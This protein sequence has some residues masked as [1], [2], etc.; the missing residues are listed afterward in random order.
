MTTPILRNWLYA[1]PAI[2]LVVVSMCAQTRVEL[3]KTARTIPKDCVLVVPASIEPQIDLAGLVKEALCKGAGEMVADFTFTMEVTTTL[4]DKKGKSKI[5]TSTYEVFVPTLKAGTSARGILVEI[6]KDGKPVPA[7]KLEKERRQA[8]EKLEKEETRLDR[9]APPANPSPG[10]NQGMA[11]IGMYSRSA[12]TRSGR[13]D[14]AF[15]VSSFLKTC[16]LTFLRRETIEGRPSLIFKFAPRAGVSFN[17]GEGYIGQMDGELAIDIE[18]HIVTKL[19]AWPIGADRVAPPAV[20]QDMVRL[21]E[22]TWLPRV[23][24]VNAAH[25][26]TLSNKVN[27]D[28]SSTFSNYVRFVTEIK[29]VKINP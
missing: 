14:L 2:V 13:I 11:P 25:Y 5:S 17:E 15:T 19:S 21:K 18:D 29:D 7:D 9:V 1:I 4:L 6:A 22:G 26:P 28:W 10:E 8:G 12:V 20:Y 27:W 3:S 24:T 23:N 16:D